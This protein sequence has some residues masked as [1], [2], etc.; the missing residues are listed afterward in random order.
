MPSSSAFSTDRA[1]S[2]YSALSEL[3]R[4]AGFARPWW[5]Q[6]SYELLAESL[7]WRYWLASRSLYLDHWEAITEAYDILGDTASR[8]Q[9]LGLLEFRLLAFDRPPGPCGEPQYFPDFLV[10]RLPPRVVWADGGAFDGDSV[11]ASESHFCTELCFA[12]EP[13]PTVYET[14]INNTQAVKSPVVRLPLG[15]SD[16]NGTL[17]FQAGAEGS[18]AVAPDGNAQLS[19][20][21]L[22]DLLHEHRIDL[23]KLD[24][25][26]HE[27]LALRGA[28]GTIRSTRPRLA[29]AAYHRWR[30]IP[31]LIR[32]LLSL[33]DDYQFYLRVHEH[34][35]FDAVLYAV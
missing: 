10:S 30:D 2:D 22:D 9:L 13:E 17:A 7:G 35:G 26:G 1:D 18:G 8:Q 19:F 15:L 31:D 34:N 25:E 28:A 16:Q 33:R 12:F 5:P 3:L 14:L 32:V 6:E 21:R 20:V 4:E 29:I 23:L 24:V 27:L 11:I